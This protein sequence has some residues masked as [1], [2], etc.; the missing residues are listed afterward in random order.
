MDF[1]YC[2]SMRLRNCR[3][4]FDLRKLVRH[5]LSSAPVC[6]EAPPRPSKFHYWVA[7]LLAVTFGLII[8]A[9][10]TLRFSYLAFRAWKLSKVAPPSIMVSRRGV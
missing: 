5:G 10:F 9:S 8:V 2:V 3:Y 7:V 6:F 1:D 4:T